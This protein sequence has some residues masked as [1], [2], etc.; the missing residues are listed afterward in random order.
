MTTIEDRPTLPERYARAMQSTH[1]EVLVDERCSVDLLVAAGWVKD[2]LG[3][4]LYR[5]RTEYDAV[6]GVH[7]TALAALHEAQAHADQ[8]R[9]EARAKEGQGQ[10]EQAARLRQIAAHIMRSADGEALMAK[11]QMLSQLK[12][13]EP[14]KAALGRFAGITATRERYMQPDGE[15]MRIAGASLDVW[16]DPMCHHCNGTGLTGG[17]GVVA[18]IC[19][20][21]GGTKL[22]VY[23]LHVTDEGHQFGRSLLSHMDR[24]TEHVAGRM[25]RFLAMR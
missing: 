15:V 2:G 25:R 23:R 6:R 12:T 22:R 19:P 17:V 18:G 3:T 9:R 13:L 24:K 8:V 1:L 21:C 5:L 10:A 7:R 16:M 14:A 20:H 4:M 11:V